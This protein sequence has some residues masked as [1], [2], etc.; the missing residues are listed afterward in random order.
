MGAS[1][2]LSGTQEKM[3]S[4]PKDVKDFQKYHRT[5]VAAK[6]A[7]RQAPLSANENER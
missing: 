4:R 6:S 5:M 3:N 7:R 1:S 2:L